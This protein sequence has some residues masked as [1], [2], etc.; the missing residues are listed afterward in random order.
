M[1]LFFIKNNGDDK[2]MAAYRG[3]HSVIATKQQIYKFQPK[4]LI[5][6]LGDRLSAQIIN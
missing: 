5:F 3:G 4:T 6:K 2:L 1:N